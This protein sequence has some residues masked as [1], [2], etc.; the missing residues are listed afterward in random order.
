MLREKALI[1]LHV[2]FIK[3]KTWCSVRTLNI[4]AKKRFEKLLREVIWGWLEE[5]LF[6][7]IRCVSLNISQALFGLE[8]LIFH[9]Q[10]PWSLGWL[11]LYGKNFI[12][13]NL[14]IKIKNYE[15][16]NFFWTFFLRELKLFSKYAAVRLVYL[17]I[18]RSYEHSNY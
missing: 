2:L 14:Q 8:D 6:I 12:I 4:L 18:A 11:V 1:W 17:E 15:N 3:N 5:K 16:T 13:N 9:F 10:L 7:Q